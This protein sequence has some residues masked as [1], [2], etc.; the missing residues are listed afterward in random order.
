MET[1]PELN[2]PAPMDGRFRSYPGDRDALA[3]G[4]AWTQ[5]EALRKE[6]CKAVPGAGRGK[7]VGKGDGLEF[8]I[9]YSVVQRSGKKAVSGVI[10]SVAGEDGAVRKI[11]E[12][13]ARPIGIAKLTVAEDGTIRYEAAPGV[14][15][16]CGVS[17]KEFADKAREM[18]AILKR[19]VRSIAE[20]GRG[21]DAVPEYRG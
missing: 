13:T 3:N 11:L 21:L 4:D 17:E 14:G 8:E 18:E 12:C 5:F 2:R 7:L 10:V 19:C 20:P 15:L 16:H 1:M 9:P 6:A